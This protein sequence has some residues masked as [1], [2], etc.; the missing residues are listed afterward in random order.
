MSMRQAWAVVAAVMA[1]GFVGGAAMAAD[2]A[3]PE[4]KAEA[5]ATAKPEGKADVKVEKAEAKAEKT[6]TN[7]EKA[8]SKAAPKTGDKLTEAAAKALK[9]AYPKATVGAVTAMKALEVEHFE[10]KENNK[11]ETT[12]DASV[13]SFQVAMK[14]EKGAEFE[15]FVGADGP[16]FAVKT[17][18]AEK[19]VPEAVAKAAKNVQGAR[20]TKVGKVEMWYV[21]APSGADPKI[22]KLEKAMIVFH[23][24]L[25]KD[26]RKGQI[27]IAEDGSVFAAAQFERNA[28]AA[29]VTVT[30]EKKA[31]TKGGDK[32]TEAA[33]KTLKETFPKATVG[34]VKATKARDMDVFEVQ[35]RDE[36]GRLI[37][38]G[39][40]A[41]GLILGIKAP[42]TEKDLPE[43]V[44]KAV[45]AIEGDKILW[46]ERM[47]MRY[48]PEPGGPPDKLTK[49][50]KA[51][52]LF[53]IRLEK[54]GLQ[55]TLFVGEDGTVQ[56][57]VRFDGKAPE[58]AAESK[59]TETRAPA[60]A[61]T[62]SKAGK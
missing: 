20:V 31:A 36:A 28:G 59:A 32:L 48:M 5:T 33:A 38:V 43:A 25:E 39:V 26:G 11:V 17:P 51:K 52:V 49:L 14:D 44:A 24:E 42:A 30:V 45:K 62:A 1:V 57:P 56:T 10:V 18:V 22:M 55:G 37:D 58:K 16:I 21:P 23:V 9:E 50:D 7:A 35:M 46:I 53:E 29:P 34:T 41:E 54:D 15:V 2:A 12:K 27:M 3:K 47:E 4:A 19:D 40:S 60:A 8:E 61:P 13:D 6:N